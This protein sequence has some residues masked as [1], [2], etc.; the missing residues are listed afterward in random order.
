MKE[1]IFMYF[2]LYYFKSFYLLGKKIKKKKKKKND[3]SKTSVSEIAL[4]GPIQKMIPR[5]N[6]VWEYSLPSD[7]LYMNTKKIVFSIC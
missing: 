4:V 7:Y 3:I 6:R 2:Y 5:V 1:E